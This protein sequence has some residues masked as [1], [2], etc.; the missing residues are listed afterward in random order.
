MTIN[1]IKYSHNFALVDPHP[2]YHQHI[3]NYVDANLT[4]IS[5]HKL[6][7]SQVVSQVSKIFAVRKLMPLEYRF[8]IS[9]LDQ[10]IE[11]FTT[12]GMTQFNITEVPMYEP[13]SCE[14]NMITDKVPWGEQP[15]LIE[16]LVSDG[17]KKIIELQAG[18]GKALRNGTPVRTING[19]TNIEDLKVGDKVMGET[20]EFHNVT[21]VYPQ[22]L[23]DLYRFTFRDG[24]TI[25]ACKEHLWCVQQYV[26]PSEPR[27]RVV[28]STADLLQ[29][30]ERELALTTLIPLQKPD[31]VLHGGLLA[32]LSKYGERKGTYVYWVYSEN[33]STETI[34]RI[35]NMC[36]RLGYNVHDYGK[37][38]IGIGLLNETGPEIV[39]IEKLFEQDYATCISVDN[40]TKLFVTKD[41]L[42][43]HN[44]FV[45]LNALSKIK[46]RAML[47][48]KPM[49]IQRWLDDLTKDT[50]IYKLTPEECV[51]ISGSRELCNVIMQA[52]AG[53]LNYKFI[54][55]S[56]RTL[57]NYYKDYRFGVNMEKY[58]GLS[59][60][61]LMETLGIGVKI[62]DEA[63]QDFHACYV[64]DLFTHVPKSIELSATLTPDDEFLRRM[65]ENVYPRELRYGGGV[66]KKYVDVVAVPY[67]IDRDVKAQIKYAQ[68]G[69]T[70]Y[71]HGALEESLMKSKKR[72]MSFLGMVTDLTHRYFITQRVPGYKLLIFASRIEM[73]KIIADH[74]KSIYPD[75][76][77]TKYTQEEDYTVL[78]DIDIIVSTPMSAGTAVD[79]SRLQVAITTVSIGA[80]QLNLQMLGR[81]REL[82]GVEKKPMFVYLYCTDIP[83][84]VEYHEKKMNQTFKNK[85]NS[86]QV[87][88]PP[89]YYV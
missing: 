74:L 31:P 54:I 89:I 35:K 37:E 36:F 7:N 81:L 4:H 44:T 23:K 67:R 41:Y 14:F 33:T 71:S 78:E 20:G 30:T 60:H 68:R 53:E 21:G 12:R 39:S 5:H 48:I 45:T 52:Q 50:G 73:C 85:V 69:R 26:S 38:G 72:M 83:K 42:V 80:T 47:I 17:K 51:V 65:Y 88:H 49:Y 32:L 56:N 64:S 58:A 57:A 27:K 79:I 75:Y 46:Q 8:H 3:K 19:W 34:A 84:H 25:D 87:L 1:I 59:P 66:Y 76:K 43:T 29:L 15:E 61:M 18:Q 6:W 62:I 28:L 9:C 13:A 24:R 11:Y 82:R 55:M 2:V 40:P 16:Y 63:H 10:F 86:Y 77:I 70:S 22:G